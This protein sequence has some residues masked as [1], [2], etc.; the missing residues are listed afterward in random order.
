MQALIIGFTNLTLSEHGEV[1]NSIG[2]EELL[3]KKGPVAWSEFVLSNS[4]YKNFTSRLCAHDQ[5]RAKTIPQ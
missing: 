3:G 2:K 1:A 4:L 5:T